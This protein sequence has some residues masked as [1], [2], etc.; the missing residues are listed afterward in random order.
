MKFSLMTSHSSAAEFRDDDNVRRWAL[1]KAKNIIN[2]S[3]PSE[4][5]SLPTFSL[6]RPPSS[7]PSLLRTQGLLQLR[8]GAVETHWFRWKEIDV[9]F[10]IAVTLLPHWT[11]PMAEPVSISEIPLFCKL[12][13]G[14][15]QMATSKS[16]KKIASSIQFFVNNLPSFQQFKNNDNLD[17]VVKYHRLLTTELLQYS[18]NHHSSAATL[19][20]KFNA[21]TLIMQLAFKSK[22]PDLYETFSL[23]EHIIDSQQAFV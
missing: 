10:T 3:L 14:D 12:I 6:P 21:I 1:K 23:N 9:L 11:Q 5:Y 17:W 18:L 16:D 2:F 4:M 15:Y 7:L 19:K 8:A 22:T 20:C 13:N